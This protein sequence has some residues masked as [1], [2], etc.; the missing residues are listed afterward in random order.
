[1]YDVLTKAE[2]T[3]HLTTVR[4]QVSNQ[5]EHKKDDKNE[6]GSFLSSFYV[7]LY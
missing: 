1:M 4:G 3:H 2:H 6:P 5:P 7:N